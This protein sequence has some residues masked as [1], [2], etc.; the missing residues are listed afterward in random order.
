MAAR[1]TPEALTAASV[2]KRLDALLRERN[3]ALRSVLARNEV[4]MDDLD[5]EIAACHA[6]YVGVAVTELALQRSAV[7]DRPQG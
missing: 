4:Y 6:A 5:A 3:T 1:S 2:R 7:H